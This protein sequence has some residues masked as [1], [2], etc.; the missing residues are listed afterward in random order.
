[1][2]M[3]QMIHIDVRTPAQL[4]S[5]GVK[6]AQTRTIFSVLS[7]VSACILVYAAM[8]TLSVP[9]LRKKV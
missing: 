7:L 4:Q 2:S 8:D 1:M 5:Q 6:P 3:V 9:L